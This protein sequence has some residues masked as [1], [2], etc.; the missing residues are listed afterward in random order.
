MKLKK[1]RIVKEKGGGN[2]TGVFKDL[3]LSWRED[4]PV[5]PINFSFKGEGKGGKEGF[6]SFLD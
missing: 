2:H 1:Y 5:F 4:M 6:P 3:W